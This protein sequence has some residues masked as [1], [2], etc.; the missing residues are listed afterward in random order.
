MKVKVG[1]LNFYFCLLKF[2]LNLNLFNLRDERS[3]LH[4]GFAEAADCHCSGY[5]VRALRINFNSF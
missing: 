5:F 2:I 4:T 1:K 3:H